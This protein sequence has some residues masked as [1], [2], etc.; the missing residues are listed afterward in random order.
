[1]NSQWRPFDLSI[2]LLQLKTPSSNAAD[3]SSN[4][5]YQQRGRWVIFAPR[6]RS[7]LLIYWWTSSLMSLNRI[8]RV[9]WLY[10]IC[11]VILR[12]TVA[13][14]LSVSMVCLIF[15]SVQCPLNS[16]KIVS[17]TMWCEFQ[18]IH[19]YIIGHN[20]CYTSADCDNFTWMML[21]EQWHHLVT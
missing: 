20:K 19:V 10:G 21:S 8:L 17:N 4:F 7:A 9:V 16:T 1:M 2:F 15:A 6:Y 14:R 5:F 13:F 12:M 3:I 11:L 18:T